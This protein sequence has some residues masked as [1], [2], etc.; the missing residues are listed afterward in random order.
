MSFA[1]RAARSVVG[2]L[3][4]LL[5]CAKPPVYEEPVT[6]GRYVMGT[7][8]E[9]TLPA[10]SPRAAFDELFDTARKLDAQLSSYSETS[11]VSRLNRSAGG[12]PTPVAGPV[13]EI[14][15]LSVDYSRRTGG[16]FDVTIGPLVELW[17]QAGD[18]GRVPTQAEIEAAKGRVGSEKIR[19]SADGTVRL[20]E[21]GMSIN[22]GGIAKG[23]ALDRMLPLLLARGVE[24][25]LLSFGQSS[26]WALGAPSGAPGWRLLVRGT[27]GDFVGLITLRDQALSV[28]ESL[29]QWVE[30]E[31][32]RFGHVV[33]PRTGQ[34][35]IRERQALVVAPTAALAEALSKLMLVA[36]AADGLALVAAQPGCDGLLIEAGGQLSAT[37]GWADSA[38]FELFSDS[39]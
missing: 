39:P 29:G 33:D 21:P 8:L 37:P 32:R 25:A 13:R 9:V 30:I 23:Y 12:A 18:R 2:L 20:E 15:E 10:D 36:D 3:A 17:M 1:G 31:G 16:A 35:L 4:A 7:I 38:R 27:T 6:D 26:T 28:S 5:S 24:S 22:L 19:V 34:P 11:D 14:L